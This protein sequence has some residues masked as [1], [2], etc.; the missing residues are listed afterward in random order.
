VEFNKQPGA[1][2]TEKI[3]FKGHFVQTMRTTQTSVV[4]FKRRFTYAKRRM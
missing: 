4:V 3:I 2:A 1:L